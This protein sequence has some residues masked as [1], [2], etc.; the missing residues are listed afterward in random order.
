MKQLE[1]AAE[2]LRET[3]GE[4]ER[5]NIEARRLREQI[6]SLIRERSI[7]VERMKFLEEA[8]REQQR[9]FLHAIVGPLTI[10]GARDNEA[11][12]VPEGTRRP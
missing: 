10:S 2:R 9:E 8:S 5:L 6:E 11:W 12:A 4:H 7:I 1:A 3:A